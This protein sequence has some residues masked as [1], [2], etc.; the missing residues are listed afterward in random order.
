[1]S[2]SAKGTIS[3]FLFQ[4][5][6]ALLLLSELKNGD[7]KVSIENVD[8]VAV[9]NDDSVIIA[10]QAKHSIASNANT[11]QDSSYALWRTIQIW[12]KKVEQ[13]IFDENTKFV[14]CTNKEVKEN[15]LLHNFVNNDIDNSLLKIK[16]LKQKQSEKLKTKKELDEDGGKS[17]QKVLTI[18]NSIFRKKK[19]LEVVLKNIHINVVSDSKGDFLAALRFNENYT[20]AQKDRIYQ[21]YYG[22]IASG[23]QAKWKQEKE[24]TFTKKDFDNKH[25]EI[26]NTRSIV[27]L[28]FRAKADLN[29][30]H[31]IHTDE[32]N[33]QQTEL[34]VRQIDDIKRRPES[35]KRIIRDAIRDFL[36]YSIEQ[37]Y[38][39]DEGNYT[40][41]DIQE[42]EKQCYEF[43]LEYFDNTVLQELEEYSEE[44]KNKLALEIFNEINSGIKLRFKNDIEFNPDNVYFQKGC[45]L[46]LSNIPEIGWRPDWEKKYL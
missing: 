26:I 23:S 17:I 38:I 14:C 7:D 18:I 43:W 20:P 13:G 31:P 45:F 24:A 22:W 16:E 6:K 44:D 32:I 40:E 2:D 29:K 36:Y 10:V 39:I 28:V 30:L 25:F 11:F 15:S 19:E 33:R 37:L 21:E 42:F 8:D 35:K 3:G 46:N 9:I 34:F 27:N 12:V 1:M 5:E 41:H 4:F